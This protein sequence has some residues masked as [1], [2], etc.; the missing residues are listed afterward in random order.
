MKYICLMLSLVFCVC[1]CSMQVEVSSK[2][3]DANIVSIVNWNLQTFFDANTVGTEYNDFRGSKS[4]WSEEKYTE[5]LE[6]L[7]AFIKK[8]QADIYIFQEIENSA[9]LQDIFNGL[10]GFQKKYTYSC[11]SKSSDEALG[12]AVFSHLPIINTNVHQLDLR[13]ALGLSNFESSKNLVD[14]MIIEQPSMRA[15]LHTQVVVSENK[16]LSLYTCHWKSKYGGAEESEVWRN[17]QERLLVDLLLE[18]KNSYLVA[19]D[20]NRTLEEFLSDE[21]KRDSPASLVSLQG[22][23][24]SIE[25]VSPW[26][27]YDTQNN[28]GGSYYYQGSWEKI[29]HF[30]YNQNLEVID[31]QVLGDENLLTAEGFPFRYD[32]YTGKGSSDHLP[33]LCVIEI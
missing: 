28:V 30:F 6:T 29:D 27:E 31:F 32:M 24:N 33:L 21:K 26:L 10:S 13:C 2:R 12:I 25:L 17:A 11:F 1:S 8:S 20:F 23:K 5:R 4:H 16:T 22:T 3:K 19:G 9:I 7:C 14:G 15:L 18:E